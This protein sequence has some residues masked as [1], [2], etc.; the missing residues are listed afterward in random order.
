MVRRKVSLVT[1]TRL[2]V[3]PLLASLQ[4]LEYF[5]TLQLPL[6]YLCLKM[7]NGKAFPNER[8]LM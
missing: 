2:S 5:G 7:T 6:S 3:I 1:V 4:N 8:V